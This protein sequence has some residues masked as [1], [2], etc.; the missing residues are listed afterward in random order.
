MVRFVNLVEIILLF[1]MGLGL[2]INMSNSGS[3]GI[4][5]RIVESKIAGRPLT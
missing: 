2:W 5:H 4:D 3:V 1:G